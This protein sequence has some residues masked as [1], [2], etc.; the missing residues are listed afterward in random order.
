MAFVTDDSSVANKIAE[1]EEMIQR[2]FLLKTTGLQGRN[3]FVF[4]SF[5]GYLA[6][7]FLCVHSPRRA[8]A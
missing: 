3:H 2:I 6:I 4:T 1:I 8:G 7:W 5:F